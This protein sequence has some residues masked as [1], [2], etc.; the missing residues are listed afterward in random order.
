MVADSNIWTYGSPKIFLRRWPEH[1][2][3][4]TDG[5]PRCEHIHYYDKTN[6]CTDVYV[7]LRLSSECDTDSVFYTMQGNVSTL[8]NVTSAGEVHC[9]CWGLEGREG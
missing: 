5:F 8:C 1:D 7:I 2:C 4:G 3:D 9:Q 6:V